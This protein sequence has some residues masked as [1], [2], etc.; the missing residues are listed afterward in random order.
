MKTSV[1]PQTAY[2][3]LN[4]VDLAD[5][6]VDAIDRG[7]IPIIITDC[8]EMVRSVVDAI[9]IEQPI[10]GNHTAKVINLKSTLA[11]LKAAV[12]SPKEQ[13]V[14]ISDQRVTCGAVKSPFVRI[15]AKKLTI[16]IGSIAEVMQ[17]HIGEDEK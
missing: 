10:V 5:Q 12:A 6:I 11:A 8:P 13:H 14:I 16:T 4:A 15:Y 7:Y 9:A 2:T 17:R 1:G 3:A